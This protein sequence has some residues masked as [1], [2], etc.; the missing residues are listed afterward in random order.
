MVMLRRSGRPYLE[1]VGEQ[2]EQPRVHPTAQAYGGEHPQ[3]HPP[4]QVLQPELHVLDG[5]LLLACTATPFCIAAWGCSSLGTGA[6]LGRHAAIAALA[7]WIRMAAMI[8]LPEFSRKEHAGQLT[9]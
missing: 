7:V 1:H 6:S 9:T 3:A 5:L 2:E 8:S 4:H